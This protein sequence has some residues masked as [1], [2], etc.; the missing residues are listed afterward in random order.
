MSAAAS[1]SPV[2][3]HI[4]AFKTGTTYLQ[5][6][7]REN[8]EALTEQ[9]VL[10]PGSDYRDQ[11]AAGRALRA[12]AGSD[13]WM[14]IASQMKQWAGPSLFSMEGMSRLDDAAIRLVAESLAGRRVRI[15]MTL[16]DLGRVI[17]SQWQELAKSKPVSGY[18]EYLDA[19]IGLDG[20]DSATYR[21]FWERQD[22][23][24]I[25]SRWLRHLPVED[26]V[27]VT[28]PP[29][30]APS[31]LLWRRFSEATGLDADRFDSTVRINESLGAAA[32]E[33][34]RQVSMNVPDHAERRTRR[35]LKRNLAN[36]LLASQQP[37]G[38]VL[39]LPKEY[40][41]AVAAKAQELTERIEGLGV[42]V[43]GELSDL[44]P[45]FATPSGPWTDDPAGLPA[46]DYLRVAAF[47]IGHLSSQVAGATSEQT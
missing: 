17:P 39:V 46:E 42:P 1:A 20:H 28:V 11:M 34:M 45:T 10:W 15:I 5:A 35:F 27:V 26:V 12:G 13:G 2:M 36:G 16:R 24:V 8:Q 32:T 33:L 19:V 7:L 29:S 23:P 18:R 6:V 30:G 3:L 25:L 47:A 44:H 22:A 40:E 21:S 37:R 14:K 31:G 43:V 38:A 4:G 9:G 41:S